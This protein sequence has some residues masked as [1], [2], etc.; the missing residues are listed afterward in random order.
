MEHTSLGQPE[1]MDEEMLTIGEIGRIFKRT[2]GAI[3]TAL[4]RH[5]RYGIDPGIP[6]PVLVGGRYRWL[7]S[8]VAAHLRGLAEQPAPEANKSEYGTRR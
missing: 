2:E 4:W 5:H 3:R 7:K 6:L 8:A 1:P